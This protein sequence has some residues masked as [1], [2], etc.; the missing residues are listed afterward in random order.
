MTEQKIY[1]M[2]HGLAVDKAE[3]PERPLSETGIEQ[4]EKIAK[5][6]RSSGTSINCIF[7]SG[8]QRAAQTAEIMAAAMDLDTTNMIE[9]LSPND[10]ITLL[11]K[12][13]NSNNALYVGHLPH[14]EHMVSQLVAGREEP[15]VASFQNSAVICLATSAE[16]NLQD[17]L[18]S[19][20]IMWYLTPESL[21]LAE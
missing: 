14:L 9:G 15:A 19:W 16:A 12:Q 21:A 5:V 20:Q 4:T 7:H 6:L 1:F 11:M 17:R 8:K 13:L 3:D 18:N 2:Q 10:D